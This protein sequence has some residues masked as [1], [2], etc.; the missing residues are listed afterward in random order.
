M[1]LDLDD[2]VP[3][4]TNWNQFMGSKDDLENVPPGIESGKTSG[5][6]LVSETPRRS[7]PQPTLPISSLML[8]TG[9]RRVRYPVTCRHNGSFSILATVSPNVMQDR[10]IHSPAPV[11]NSPA[12]A[13]GG[14][15]AP[16]RSVSTQPISS[17]GRYVGHGTD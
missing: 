14:S 6:S 1:I 2:I 12:F 4:D 16:T 8:P 11:A 10:V 9:L 15:P 7:L 5:P 17:R 13:A 3:V